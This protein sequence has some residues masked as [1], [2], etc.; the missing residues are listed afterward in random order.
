MIIGSGQVLTASQNLRRE[1]NTVSFS[2][3]RRATATVAGVDS[4]LGLGVLAVDTGDLPA[5]AWEPGE[6]LGIGAAVIA[7]ADPGGRGLR[8]TQGFVSSAPRSFRGPRGR[9]VRGAIEHTAPLPR[10]SSGAPW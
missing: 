5:V 6:E 7:V 4:D 1:E 3:G 9:R 8:A 10:G 2:D